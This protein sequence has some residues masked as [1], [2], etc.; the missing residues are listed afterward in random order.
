MSVGFVV[1]LGS[2]GVVRV[3]ERGIVGPALDRQAQVLNQIIPR[4][5]ISCSAGGFGQW[6]R[7]NPLTKPTGERP[8][9]ASRTDF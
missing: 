3:D 2:L 6:W 5:Q 1:A 8:P 9:R 7:L 4:A